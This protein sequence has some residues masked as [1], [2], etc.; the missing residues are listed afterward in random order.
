M[1][2]CAKEGEALQIS[3][4]IWTEEK[5]SF[6]QTLEWFGLEADCK[7]TFLFSLNHLNKKQQQEIYNIQECSTK[8]LFTF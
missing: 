8:L 5:F 6:R 3:E 2:E 7:F 4:V 1:N